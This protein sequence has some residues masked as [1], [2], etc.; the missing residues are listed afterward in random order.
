M[1]IITLLIAISITIAIVFLAVFVWSLRSGQFDDT[2]TPAM[3]I[4]FDDRKKQRE[5]P[6][7]TASSKSDK[8]QSHD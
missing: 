7:A 8:N 5:A 6:E 2:T 1:G 4:L 3:R